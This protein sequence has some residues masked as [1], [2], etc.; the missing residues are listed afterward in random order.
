[1]K[2]LTKGI[3]ESTAEKERLAKEKE[4]LRV[5]FNEI[6]KKAFNVQDNFN[7]TQKV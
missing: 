1:M 2:K 6:E 5:K 7:K 4:N 3:E